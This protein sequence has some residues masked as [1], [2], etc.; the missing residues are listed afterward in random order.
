MGRDD[1]RWA[2]LGLTVQVRSRERGA[3]GGANLVDLEVVEHLEHVPSMLW[4]CE[5]LHAEI[6][7]VV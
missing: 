7:E 6:V 3:D 4:H 5:W 2:I 1:A